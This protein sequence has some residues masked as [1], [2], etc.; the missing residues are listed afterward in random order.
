MLLGSGLTKGGWGHSPIYRVLGKWSYMYNSH[1]EINPHGDKR[2]VGYF[3]HTLYNKVDIF[4][5]QF[6]IQCL[7][8]EFYLCPL[9]PHLQSIPL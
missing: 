5:R 1:N 2:E 9:W 6:L 3:S 4:C 7:K 8:N